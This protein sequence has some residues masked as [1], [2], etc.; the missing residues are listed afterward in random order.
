MTLPKSIDPAVL[1]E[2]ITETRA[3]RIAKFL[4]AWTAAQEALK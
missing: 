2:V 4:Q 3:M 1:A